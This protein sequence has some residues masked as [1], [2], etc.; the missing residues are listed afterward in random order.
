MLNEGGLFSTG[1]GHAAQ[2]DGEVNGAAMETVAHGNVRVPGVRKDW[3]GDY[4]ARKQRFPLITF[5]VIADRTTMRRVRALHEMLD[6]IV[7]LTGIS[8][9]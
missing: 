9:R 2:G 7:S 4:R 5:G 8:R 3:A 1:D 6:S